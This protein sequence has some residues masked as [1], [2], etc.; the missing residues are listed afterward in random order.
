MQTKQPHDHAGHRQ[1]LMDK[2]IKDACCEHEYLE[3][4]LC[5]AIPRRITN[6]LAHRLLA[7]FGTVEQVLSASAEQ[8]LNV[9][10]VGKTTVALLKCVHKFFEEY[11]ALHAGKCQDQLPEIYDGERFS[12]Y[13]FEKYKNVGYETLDVY[14]LNDAGK[15]FRE[16]SFTSKKEGSVVVDVEEL[17]RLCASLHP[18][19]IVLVHNHP[20]GGFLPS[21]RDDQATRNCQYICNMHNVLLCNHFIVSPK[22]VYDYYA[23]G[24]LEKINQECALKSL[25]KD[26]EQEETA[27]T[28]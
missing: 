4:I 19:G 11:V 25:L 5:Y 21:K 28:E 27:Q 3:M 24:Q 10:G 2:V 17:S 13:V 23:S 22:G 16:K 1:R 18:S 20:I 14:F 7:E 15:F 12:Q 26:A 6:D 9:K 8:L